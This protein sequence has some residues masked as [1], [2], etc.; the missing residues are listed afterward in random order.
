MSHFIFTVIFFVLTIQCKVI[1]IISPNQFSNPDQI[2][3]VNFC[4]DENEKCLE[5]APV[6]NDVSDYL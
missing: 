5:L 1:E 2:W 3:L 4:S 6:W